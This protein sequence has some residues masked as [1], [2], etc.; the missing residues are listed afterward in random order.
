MNHDGKLDLV[1]DWGTALGNGKGQFGKPIPLPSGLGAIMA[2][3]PGDFR[4]SGTV[5]LAV[6]SSTYSAAMQGWTTAGL[7]LHAFRQWKWFVHGEPPAI[8][9]RDFPTT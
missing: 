4:A 2:L 5:D 6:A 7:R 9:S 1:G 3:A 8:Y